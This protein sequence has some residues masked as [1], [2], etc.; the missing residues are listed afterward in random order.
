MF[1]EMGLNMTF[2]DVVVNF[3]SCQHISHKICN[4][5]Q[6]NGHYGHQSTVIS[7]KMSNVLYFFR[8]MVRSFRHSICTIYHSFSMLQKTSV[9]IF[10][11]METNM[12]YANACEHENSIFTNTSRACYQTECSLSQ[13]I[14]IPD[15]SVMQKQIHTLPHI[16][17]AATVS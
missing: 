5:L 8:W 3:S 2:A 9:H 12:E 17:N 16:L 4:G 14:H 11:N 6:A 10:M 15:G 7:V 13:H 1:G